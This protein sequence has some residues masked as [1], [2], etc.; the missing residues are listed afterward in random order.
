MEIIVIS[1]VIK[2]MHTIDCLLKFL[3]YY[4]NIMIGRLLLL[5]SYMLNL[6]Q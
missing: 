1:S 5:N 3:G 4:G 6:V 2:F